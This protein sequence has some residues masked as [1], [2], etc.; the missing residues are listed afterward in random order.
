MINIK[1]LLDDPNVILEKLK[2]RGYSLDVDLIKKLN[3]KRKDTITIKEKLSA[4]KNKISDA[5]KGQ[6]TDKAK[7]KLKEDS[8][9][10]EKEISSNKIALLDIESK[11]NDQL[12]QIPNIPDSG[13]PIGDE[14]S[15]KV[16]KSWGSPSANNNNDHSALFEKNKLIDFESG[17]MLAK[18]RFTVMHSG[19][20]KLHRSLI[21][22]MLDKHIANG[23]KEYYLPYLVNSESLIGT[24]Q[25]PKFEE[26]LF[27]IAG[28]DLYLIPTGEVPLTGLYKNSILS[29][30]ELPIRMVSHTPCFRSEAGSYG[31]D[32]RGMIRQHQFDKIELV[33]IVMPSDSE[34]VL[35]EITS[36]AELLL[37]LLELPYQRV[38]L[39]SEDIGFSAAKT[40]DIE[41][42]MPS[43]SSYREV[44][45]CSCFTDFQ[46]R[47]L[48]I[49][50]KDNNKN[51][52]HPYTLNGSGLAVGRTLVALVE[53]HTK[54]NIINIPKALQDYFGDDV[55]KL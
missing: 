55:L 33:Q 18:S 47:R 39:A 14:N 30:S 16:I 43:Q 12:L 24:G 11:L 38:L 35:E 26:D 1:N 3:T 2:S 49:K 51:K 54:D 50:Y 48:N 9:T 22:F 46:S 28:E 20:A 32:T 10:L 5:F 52:I 40:F 42:W 37:E 27:K 15:N 34:Q 25:L 45:S 6:A 8:Q 36:S 21:S 17:V 4:E 53:N 44:S 13:I 23:Y 41:V 7:A 19:L 31:K 29:E